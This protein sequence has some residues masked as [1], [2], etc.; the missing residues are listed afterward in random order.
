MRKILLAVLAF[1]F[2]TPAQAND[3][4][5]DDVAACLVRAKIA[6][7]SPPQSQQIDAYA[8]QGKVYFNNPFVDQ[9]PAFAFWKCLR[10]KG[11]NIPG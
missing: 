2:V 8:A 10:L 6:L 9:S 11:Y 4:L 3:A 7:N 1:S 5:G